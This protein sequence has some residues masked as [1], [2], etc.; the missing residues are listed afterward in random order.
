MQ[1][2]TN[3]PDK[4]SKAKEVELFNLQK[5]YEGLSNTME[6]PIET[7]EEGIVNVDQAMRSLIN[8]MGQ[9]E[10]YAK[11]IREAY[12][13]SALEIIKMG[14]TQKD[15]LTIQQETLTTLGRNVV[16]SA[17]QTKE[18]YA[19][20]QVTGVANAK[21]QEGFMSAGMAIKDISK[22]M[23]GVRD[24]ANSLGVNA[25]QV[26]ETVVTN[27]GKLNK[28]GF[29]GGVEGLAR[30]A[31]KAQVLKVS[32]ESTFN[33]ADDLMSP[34]KAIE[35]S[36][37][38]QRLGASSAELTDPLKLMDLAQN[39]V[40][41][42]QN[43][44]GQMFK[45][46]S[47]FDEKTKRF[48]IMPGA[49][50]QL[51]EIASELGMTTEEAERFALGAADLDKKLSEIS[52][53]GFDV[54][55]DTKELVANMAMMNE[56]G[57]YEIKTSEVG[58]D[59]KP[60]TKSIQEIMEQF[61]GDDEGLKK[62]LTGIQEQEEIDADPQKKMVQIAQAQLD[63]FTS[64]TKSGEAAKA[65][66][67]LK[68]GASEVG[69]A[70]LQA[71]KAL[72][73]AI[74]PA[75][76]KI[77]DAPGF[78][79]ASKSL[80]TSI[81][82]L[83][84]TLKNP[85]S[86]TEEKQKAF[87]KV[88]STST[89]TMTSLGESVTDQASNIAK[90]IL[91]EELAG[92]MYNRATLAGQKLLDEGKELTKKARGKFGLKD[93]EDVQESPPLGSEIDVEEAP[94]M[95][96]EIDVEEAPPTEGKIDVEEAPT[97]YIGKETPLSITAN[98]VLLSELNPKP[99]EFPDIDT[100]KASKLEIEESNV[101]DN[102][103]LALEGFTKKVDEIKP[104]TEA[105]PETT[106]TVAQTIN[107]EIQ[108]LIDEGIVG[109]ATAGIGNEVFFKEKPT[110]GTP[111][112]GAEM[113]AI[114][115][116]TAELP[117]LE[118]IVQKP[119]ESEKGIFG[120]LQKRISSLKEKPEE[121]SSL[122]E[123]YKEYYEWLY[124]GGA[125]IIGEGKD[126]YVFTPPTEE[127][128]K[129]IQKNDIVGPS[130][131]DQPS[132]ITPPLG[133]EMPKKEESAESKEEYQRL[134]KEIEKELEIE[135]YDKKVNEFND[136]IKNF[137]KEKMGVGGVEKEEDLSKDD[138]DTLESMRKRR[139][140][141]EEMSYALEY[142]EAESF[143][144]KNIEPID[145]LGRPEFELKMP[146]QTPLNQLLKPEE[147][148]KQTLGEKLKS[149]VGKIKDKFKKEEKI[150][151]E[152]ATTQ[153][154]QPKYVV[155]DAE[156][157]IL[158]ESIDKETAS[159]KAGEAG[160]G[161]EPELVETS[162]TETP[163]TENKEEKQPLGKR[164]KEGFKKLI[165]EKPEVEAVAEETTE[166]PKTLREKIGEGADKLGRGVEKFAGKIGEKFDGSKLKEKIKEVKGKIKGEEEL[167]KTEPIQPETVK[168]NMFPLS[169]YDGPFHEEKDGKI[170]LRNPY[171]I[172]DEMERKKKEAEELPK[173][174]PI[175]PEPKSQS[176]FND[177]ERNRL[178]SEVDES[179][180]PLYSERQDGS[181]VYLPE[182]R[183]SQEEDKVIDSLFE[184]KPKV[185][186]TKGEVVE[187][188]K[189][190]EPK[191]IVESIKFTELYDD[192]DG[193]MQEPVEA[194]EITKGREDKKIASDAAKAAQQ[195]H[196]DFLEELRLAELQP[197]TPQKG[198]EKIAGGIGKIGK[199]GK[200]LF[201]PTEE[202]P[203]FEEFMPT[204]ETG[205]EYG[206]PTEETGFEFTP[207]E[208]ED[209]GFP[210]PE[211]IEAPEA[212]EIGIP[213]IPTPQGVS[214]EFFGE[215]TQQGETEGGVTVDGG[216]PIQV[217]VTHIFK[218]LPSSIDTE[219]LKGILRTDNTIQQAITKAV[220]G[221]SFGLNR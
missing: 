146:S 209:Y 98:E 29:Q 48:Q 51:K 210:T 52:F 70:I 47:F 182:E 78:K 45:Q 83:T 134:L 200:K 198:I 186:K 44:L 112:I 114:P 75:L 111:E 167:P 5:G 126:A 88:A 67:G 73:D 68:V 20:S 153:G 201:G 217:E 161:I 133:K 76:E 183:K 204:E 49:R 62:Y 120:E 19:A 207:P 14:G 121:E 137:K 219:Q 66:S 164:I 147:E 208:E 188:V 89:E 206:T 32:M 55:Q 169:N 80:V 141:Y 69:P 119:K 108:K 156:G 95:G 65:A 74:N 123:Q 113:E 56:K 87:Q 8:Q 168:E 193:I 154:E 28:Y 22:E 43:Q 96:G 63:F 214:D 109:E 185:E 53:A 160:L 135:S 139:D 90:N 30:M 37:A 195:K 163:T 38:L 60:V 59:G 39:N 138:L 27:L 36:S 50:R 3:E 107:P 175:A 220:E 190:E 197:E 9:G 71:N 165:E 128:L 151:P 18:L 171:D 148:E 212:P 57:E 158:S 178:L 127:E 117:T 92:E 72:A 17:E 189:P 196:L 216:R 33:L 7:I 136:E 129:E 58:Q 40:P 221:V 143:K 176:I 179:G 149:G 85:E 93:E 91:G 61:K 25:K 13:E 54:E 11:N 82:E 79:Y 97:N 64:T 174:E 192:L 205:F 150:E 77:A 177:E 194:F 116:T 103:D 122:Y 157:N 21:L 106:P 202:E 6:K 170:V 81:E 125:E 152:E 46:Y 100:I 101:I 118:D 131:W 102:L 173:T 142:G 184:T 31:S 181:L 211:E 124:G 191:S 86:T 94:P 15:A 23:L 1:D 110:V 145:V 4:T 12:A 172:L 10:N 26:S 159:K 105:K 155:K 218:N 140:N 42:L 35:L 166:E 2:G 180:N 99:L 144:P 130:P 104:T 213:E 203:T 24:V 115:E 199:I 215:Q 16:L 34:E 84:K 187:E 132:Q 41:E 162:V